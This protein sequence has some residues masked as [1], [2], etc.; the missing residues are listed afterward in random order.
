VRTGEILS[1]LLTAWLFSGFRVKMSSCSEALKTIP[2][3]PRK[4]LSAKQ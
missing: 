4:C 1:K 3:V 2:S